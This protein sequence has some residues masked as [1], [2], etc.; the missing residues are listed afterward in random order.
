MDFHKCSHVCDEI[1]FNEILGEWQRKYIT[2]AYLKAVSAL[3][4]TVGV[5]V[6]RIAAAARTRALKLLSGVHA[7]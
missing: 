5:A 1:P 2:A 3:D 4:S 6:P 7:Y